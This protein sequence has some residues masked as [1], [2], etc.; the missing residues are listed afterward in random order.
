[1][2]TKHHLHEKHIYKQQAT[3][4][5]R[6]LCENVLAL[7][8]FL[9]DNENK[10]AAIVNGIRHIKMITEFLGLQLV[11]MELK[12]LWFHHLGFSVCCTAHEE[13]LFI[14]AIISSKKYFKNLCYRLATIIRF[15]AHSDFCINSHKLLLIELYWQVCHLVTLLAE[16]ISMFSKLNWANHAK[17]WFPFIS[18]QRVSL[19]KWN[20]S[21]WKQNL[22]LLFQN[23]FLRHWFPFRRYPW[24]S[25]VLEI[26]HSGNT[27]YYFC[28]K[29]CSWSIDFRLED[30]REF[31]KY[32]KYFILETKPSASVLKSVPH[33]SP[34]FKRL[35]RFIFVTKSRWKTLFKIIEPSGYIQ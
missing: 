12:D 5:W 24:V 26:F 35:C 11:G 30:T 22:L 3:V 27:T 14:S 15:C 8:L 2:L 20:I 23:L 9:F 6:F 32:S 25:H 17:H 10:I 29:I 4:W 28:S 7:S 16:R 21:F 34:P 33:N 18:Y 31:P 19:C 13:N 1:M